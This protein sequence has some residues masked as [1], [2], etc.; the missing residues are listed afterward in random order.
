MTDFI[1]P[2]PPQP[3]IAIA[4]FAARFP[5]RRVGAVATGDRVNGGID[6]IGTIELSLGPPR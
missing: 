6:G 2:P 1:F 5:V 3:S 4:G